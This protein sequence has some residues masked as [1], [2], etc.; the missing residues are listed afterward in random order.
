MI[1]KI[2]DFLKKYPK[3]FIAL[4]YS[5]ASFFVCLPYLKDF[6]HLILPGDSFF[7]AW[8]IGWNLHALT[9]DPANFWNGN[10]FFPSKN[11][12][13]FSDG[14]FAQTAMAIPFFALTKSLI[15]SSNVLILTSYFLAAFSAYLLAFYHTRKHIPSFIAGLIFGFA[16]YR[17][18]SPGHFQNLHIFWMPL[19][20]L[21]LQK[22]LDLGKR[23]YL[24]FFTLVFSGQMLSSWYNGYFLSLL[25]V[26]FLV[27]NFSAIRER[28]KKDW[29]SFLLAGLTIIILVS[30]FAY[31]YVKL[32]MG[33]S[34]AGYSGRRLTVRPILAA[35]SFPRR[36]L[37][38]A[39]GSP[40]TVSRK[41]NGAKICTFSA[42]F[43]FLRFCSIFS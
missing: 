18:V 43:L 23:K 15:F 14:L 40:N 32:N 7:S 9:N 27:Y 1:E 42:S 12:L 20:I 36:S 26:F 17:I 37:R 28:L 35:I 25:V 24:V 5:V 13:A 21:F 19:A 11:T 3:T 30:P 34:G 29:K 6:S 31:P 2:S 10:I 16:T 33:K 39:N 41:R 8:T 38:S 4:A 22:Y